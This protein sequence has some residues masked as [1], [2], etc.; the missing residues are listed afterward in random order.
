LAAIPAFIG[1]PGIVALAG[2]AALAEPRLQPL[3]PALAA[4]IVA[5]SE[6]ADISKSEAD[7]EFETPRSNDWQNV[8]EPVVAR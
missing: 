7:H 5:A 1:C 4:S 6:R 8:L 2:Q 3:A